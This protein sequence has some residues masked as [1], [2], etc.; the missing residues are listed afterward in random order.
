MLR[1]YR[2]LVALVLLMVLISTPATLVVPLLIEQ[3]I[4]NGLPSGEI[5]QLVLYAVL[6]VIIAL[7]RAAASFFERFISETI[8]INVAFDLRNRL[9]NHIQYMSFSFHD[10]AQTGQLISRGIEDVRSTRRFVGAG[11]PELLR[12]AL[13]VAGVTFIIFNANPRLA[14]IAMVP[15]LVLL[16]MTTRFG[17]RVGRLFL[18]VD[19]AMGEIS[20][21]VQ[22][23]A[24][25]ALVVRAFSRQSYEIERFTTA[26]QE[27]Y[28]A[29]VNVI[30][31][32]SKIMPTGRVMVSLSVILV[33]W[34]GG[35][36]VLEGEMSVGELVAFIGYIL[37]LAAP[38]QQLTQQVNL[39]GEAQA[40]IERIYQILEKPAEISSPA[41]AIVL[42][43]L[44][45][46]VIFDQVTVRYSGQS[47]PALSNINLTVHPNELVALIGATGSGKTTLVNLI[48]R[49]YD[50]SLGAVLVDGYNVKAVELK[51]L[52]QQI[53]IVPQSSRLFSVTIQENIAYGRP[54]AGLEEIKRAAVAA[55]AHEFILNLPEGYDT[56]V[57][58]RG[59]TLSGGQ[60]QRVAIARALLM[61]PRILLL[62]DSTSSVDLETETLI[63]AALRNLMKGR[64]TLVIAHRLSTV[65]QADRILVMEGGQIVE[66]GRHAQLIESSGLYREIYEL[67]LKSQDELRN[68][69]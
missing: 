47:I 5:S 57:G 53:G 36:S 31:E 46:E 30:S 51:S 63:Q 64:T 29:R 1:P 59:V 14:A 8:S 17:T 32:W 48:P 50:T 43:R 39:A 55:Q 25:G 44:S 61:D 9:Y 18:A 26:N 13:L 52:R 69:A 7:I 60:R 40:G 4:D 49:F 33:L 2:R 12:V 45:G 58:E 19:R 28:D 3:F 21:K 66:E 23:N 15:I 68:L 22:E 67:Q 62:D 20:T 42:P 54:E 27:L 65:R 41:D 35:N 34:F 10:F 38:S 37:I 56:V 16:G 6:I 11:A 24:L